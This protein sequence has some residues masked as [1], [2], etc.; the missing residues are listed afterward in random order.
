MTSGTCGRSSTGSS[1]SV[2]LTQCLASRLKTL[3]GKGGLMEY[4]EIWKE[5]VTPSG[6]WYWEH[7]ASTRRISASGCIG[8]PTPRTSDCRG[9]QEVENREGSPALHTVA[10]WCSPT[11]TDG[12]R[13]SLP[14]RPQDTGV[15]LSQQ[16]AGIAGWPTPQCTQ[17]PNMSMNRGEDYGG[18]RAR[19]TPQSV[20]GILAG[21]GTPRVGNNGGHGNP[22]RAS[23]G[24]AKIEDQVHGIIPDSSSAGTISF[25]GY[26]LNQKFSLWLQGFPPSEWAK[27][28]PGWQEWDLVQ[29][30]LSEHSNDPEAFWQW[31]AS[32][33]LESS[34]ELETPSCRKSRRSSSKP[35]SGEEN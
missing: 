13:G 15:P 1:A 33:G 16:V 26:Q 29:S 3:L 10:G 32:T 18:R 31:L 7:T 24:M 4:A 25:A 9:A 35:S 6:R 11:A 20:E 5:R 8:W 14:P 19:V 2:A 34:T 27:C 21:W 12:A 23:D 30:K 17:G 28:A 22:E